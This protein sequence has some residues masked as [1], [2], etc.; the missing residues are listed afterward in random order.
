[1]KQGHKD[2]AR[3]IHLYETWN[4]KANAHNRK[5]CIRQTKI[6]A[7]FTPRRRTR[8]LVATIPETADPLS[9]RVLEVSRRTT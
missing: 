3:L 8:T 5:L 9:A 2:I 1:M 7:S 6:A 4:T